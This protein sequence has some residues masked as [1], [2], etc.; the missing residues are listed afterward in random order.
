[1]S[2]LPYAI[3]SSLGTQL[4]QLL[5][6][7]GWLPVAKML[8]SSFP[9]VKWVLPHAPAIPITINHGTSVKLYSSPSIPC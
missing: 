8:W 6:G 7:H 1:M 5:A 9:N 2:C 3:V 4:M